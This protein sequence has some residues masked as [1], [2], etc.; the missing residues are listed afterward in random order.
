MT[1]KYRTNSWSADSYLPFGE[2]EGETIAGVE[3]N[4]RFPGQYHDRSTDLHYNMYRHYRTDLG[5][6]LT[7][8]PIGIAGGLNMYSYAG[9]NPINRIDPLGLEDHRPWWVKLEAGYYYGTGYGESAVDYYAS[10]IADRESTGLQRAGAWLGGVFATLWTED[11]WMT[12][13]IGVASMGG[14]QCGVSRLALEENILSQGNVYRLIS[15]T[16]SVGLRIDPAHHGKHW[17]HFHFW[18]W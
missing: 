16:L 1:N 8:D 11:M 12:T 13:A 18:R 2:L 15:R 14:A 7:P 6:Y 3:N 10:V 4:L 5:R 17:G 9:Q